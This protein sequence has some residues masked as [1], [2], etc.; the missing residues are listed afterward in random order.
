MHLGCWWVALW[1]LNGDTSTAAAYEYWRM[2]SE[3][4]LRTW[5]PTLETILGCFTV[6]PCTYL[7]WVQ[8]GLMMMTGL[9]LG[10]SAILARGR[11]ASFCSIHMGHKICSLLLENFV[12]AVVLVYSQSRQNIC[13]TRI[14]ESFFV[15]FHLSSVFWK[16]FCVREML[17]TVSNFIVNGR[18]YSCEAKI[19]LWWDQNII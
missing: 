8:L 5:G 17:P 6:V 10:T 9:I 11:G 2:Q 7:C 12:F 14:C 19:V 4:C 18:F 3:T 13:P 1:C 15:K 16:M